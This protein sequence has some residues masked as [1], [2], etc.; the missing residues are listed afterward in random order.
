MTD[1]LIGHL[2]V[3][4]AA[5][6]YFNM[7]AVQKKKRMGSHIQQR[8]HPLGTRYKNYLSTVDIQS[9][10]KLSCCLI[11]LL[12]AGFRQN[13][14]RAYCRDIKYQADQVE[15]HIVTSWHIIATAVSFLN[16][17]VALTSSFSDLKKYAEK[18]LTVEGHTMDRIRR[19]Y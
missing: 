13:L 11:Y 2:V 7:I 12:V 18:S 5:V 9:L 17:G 19:G 15:T 14:N 6:M 10:L 16:A 3:F 8:N 1:F 4:W